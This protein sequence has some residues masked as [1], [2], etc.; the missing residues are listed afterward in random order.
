[1]LVTSWIYCLCAGGFYTLGLTAIISYGKEENGM[2]AAVKT[3]QIDLESIKTAIAKKI[4]SAG[5]VSWIAPLGF[6]VTGRT[7]SLIAQNQFSADFIK[8]VYL[9]TLESVAADFGLALY[10]GT[11]APVQSVAVGANDNTS[12]NFIPADDV[13]ASSVCFDNFVTSGDNSFV[14][15]ACKKMATGSASFSP[16]FVYGPSGCGKSLLAECINSTAPGRTLMMTGPQFVSEF[17]RAMREHSVFAFKDFCRNC[18]TFIL[19]DV[20]ALSGKRATMDEFLHLILDLRAS[21]RNIVLVANAAP[22]N[23][24]GFDR[25]AQSL[26]ASGLV[27]DVAAPDR[28]VKHAMLVRN[29]V[30]H[31]VAEMLAGHIGGDGHLVAGVAKKIMTYAELM[32]ERVTIQI[33]E[34]LLSDTLQKSKTPLA[35]VKSMCEKLGVSYDAMC[36]PSRSRGLVR[37]RQ[38]MMTALKSAT[39]LSLAEIGRLCG[40]RDHA[41]V[42]YAISQIE[43]LKS[44]D[45]LL[46]AEMDQLISECR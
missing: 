34:K 38:M 14:V 30:A 6:D 12:K 21:G 1:M 46:T 42:L 7:L 44:S 18:D 22:G 37:A 29:G 11:G 13:V 19:D 17:L 20:Q 15:S 23:L 25:R 26:L 27:A 36:G 43:K 35:M 32:N 39:K 33:A 45:L 3:L 8:S 40:D 2:Q 9:K 5:F 4:D 31:D 28:F 24:V 16:L 10:I 41:T